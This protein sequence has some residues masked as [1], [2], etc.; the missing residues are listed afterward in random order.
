METFLQKRP[1]SGRPNLSYLTE[2][3]REAFDEIYD[4]LDSPDQFFCLAGDAGTGKTTLASYI[5]EDYI[6]SRSGTVCASALTNKATLVLSQKCEYYDDGL[7]FCTIHSLLN[8][9]PVIDSYGNEK[10]K[11]DKRG[12]ANIVNFS[13]VVVDEASML[14]NKLFVELYGKVMGNP[15]IKV[16][17][18]GD[19]FQL[20]PIN[21]SDAVPF[22][23]EQRKSKGIKYFKLDKIVRQA[24][25]NPIIQFSQQLRRMVY[26]PDSI[27]GDGGDGL[28]MVPPNRKS[29][30]LKA[31]FCNEQYDNDPLYC[32]VIA[33]RNATVDALNNYIRK[34]KYGPDIPALIPGEVLIADKPIMDFESET[35][36]LF[37]TNEELAIDDCSVSSILA[38]GEEYKIYIACARSLTSGKRQN[39]NLVHEDSREQFN[40]ELDKLKE[41]ALEAKQGTKTARNRW[42]EYYAFEK[43]FARCKYSFALTAHKSQGTTV[44][45]CIVMPN[46]ILANP[47]KREA[48]R[49]L[50][51]AV[52]RPSQKLLLFT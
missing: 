45:N 24:E 12:E 21:H 52:T 51:T 11:P 38:R 36:I 41:W 23:P 7:E 47:K 43:K 46:D 2:Q 4:W 10:F 6:A 20:N 25:G 13:F 14:D 32:K 29:E 37:F 33:W 27:V 1:V 22:I 40:S 18:V 34:L 15:H 39:I 19:D 3:Q 16:L 50:Y 49:C 35:E 8:V 17:F 30:C 42:I 48:Y 5:I 44:E 26:K 31:F 9:R 28:W